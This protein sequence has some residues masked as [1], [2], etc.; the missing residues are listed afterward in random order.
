MTS[1]FTVAFEASLKEAIQ[2]GNLE[3]LAGH[4]VYPQYF[5]CISGLNVDKDP[6]PLIRADTQ[7]VCPGVGVCVDISGSWSPTS[8]ISLW[9]VDWGDGNNSNGAW[10]PPAQVC[11]PLGGYILF[12]T[13]EVTLTVTDLLGASAEAIAEIVVLVCPP[14]PPPAPPIVGV[15]NFGPVYTTGLNG[16]LTIWQDLDRAALTVPGSRIPNAMVQY[17]WLDG[18]SSLYMCTNCGIYEYTPLP[19]GYGN[20]IYRQSNLQLTL[21]LA[22]P[23]ASIRVWAMEMS[24]ENEGWGVCIFATQPFGPGTFRLGCATTHDGWVTINNK[25][26]ISAANGMGQAR[27]DVAIAQHSGMQTIYACSMEWLNQNRLFRSTLEGAAG[28]W[29]NIHTIAGVSLNETIVHCPYYSPSHTDNYIY[30]GGMDNI[31]RSTDGGTVFAFLCDMDRIQPMIQT[32]MLDLNRLEGC[33]WKGGAVTQSTLYYWTPT[34]GVQTFGPTWGLVESSWDQHVMARNTATYVPTSWLWVGSGGVNV[35]AVKENT[36]VAQ[37]DHSGNIGAVTGNVGHCICL[38][39]RTGE[40]PGW[41][42]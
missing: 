39:K 2:G 11:H 26:T 3:L 32:P 15:E 25:S 23:T 29:A 27:C 8:T 19:A 30:W 13:Y 36:A 42:L 7:E 33:H 5:C 34:G 38:T 24:M 12:G 18:H 4:T 41:P 20:W 37:I 14:D 10:P 22:W 40:E 6:V 28:S 21:G 9:D 31:Y 35:P 17:D 16:P 1:P